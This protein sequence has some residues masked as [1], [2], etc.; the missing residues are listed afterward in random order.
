MEMLS[1]ASLGKTRLRLKS[2]IYQRVRDKAVADDIVQDVFVKVHNKLGQLK[3]TEKIMGWLYQI[4]RNAITDH[5]R[6]KSKAAEPWDLDWEGEPKLLNDC[7]SSCLGEMLLTLP[8][9]YKLAL[10]MAEM[11]DLSQTELAERMQISYSGAKSRVQRARKMLRQK[12]D[13]AYVIKT[14]SYGNVTVCESRVPCHCTN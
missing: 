13:E 14:D 7:V 9:K 1:S 11:E 2:F 10:E 8:E 12:M 6:V 4:T 3:D 5:F